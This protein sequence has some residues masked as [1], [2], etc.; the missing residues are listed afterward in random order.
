M[1]EKGTSLKV[2]VWI[3]SGSI[4]YLKGIRLDLA[5]GYSVANSM[6]K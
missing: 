4:S 3:N 6:A 5:A 2:D 1:T